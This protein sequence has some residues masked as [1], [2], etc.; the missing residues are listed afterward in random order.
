MTS[1]ELRF[2]IAHW[3]FFVVTAAL[4]FLLG[5]MGSK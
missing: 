4:L 1:E 5:R 3:P 2:I